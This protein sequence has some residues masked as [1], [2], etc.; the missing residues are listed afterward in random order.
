MKREDFVKKYI[1]KY[2]T[3][4]YRNGMGAN[5]LF[6]DFVFFYT[7]KLR[8]Q[9][10]AHE[11]SAKEYE[12]LYNKY[13]D[14]IKSLFEEMMHDLI[15]SINDTT[16]DYLGRMYM[17][18]GAN[19]KRIGQYYTPFSVSK[20]MAKMSLTD[21]LKN[22]KD[23][24]P[25]SI[26]DPCCGSGSLMIAAVDVMKEMNINY[27]YDTVIY[28]Q[29]IDPLAASMC[30]LQLSVLGAAA[31]VNI[32]DSIKMDVYDSLCTIAYIGQTKIRELKEAFAS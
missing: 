7:S 27:A 29:D 3:L 28:A 32:G 12:R 4:A 8:S 22:K 24:L 26:S 2:E 13:S 6:Y 20:L 31:V 10:E 21:G 11:K 18:L 19:K 30:Y 17:E 14:E 15:E 5:E 25:L 23:N 9:T 1:K 16:D